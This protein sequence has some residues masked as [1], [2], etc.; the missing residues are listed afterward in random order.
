MKRS[1]LLLSLVALTTLGCDDEVDGCGLD[2]DEPQINANA[3]AGVL[4]FELARLQ[5]SNTLD[6]VVINGGCK[7]LELDLDSVRLEGADAAEFELGPVFPED[8]SA[9]ARRA[10]GIPITF[11]S[12]GRGVYLSTLV[13]ESN[14][15]NIPLYELDLIG[16]A[17]DGRIPDEA[18][19]EFF[20]DPVEVA[21]SAALLDADGN[22]IDVAIIRF[23]NLGGRSLRVS[24]YNLVDDS[25]FAFLDGT[26]E[27]SAACTYSKVCL[28]GDGAAQGCCEGGLACR[29]LEFALD[30]QTCNTSQCSAVNVTSGQ[31]SILAL[32][33]AE[34]TPTGTH[35]TTLE[36][37]SNDP[38]TPVASVT[39]TGTK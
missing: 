15:E 18:D 5:E 9:L 33:W 36:I 29:C 14:A 13:F 2:F 3:L 31:F 19:I 26:A 23:Y 20:E 12:P 21:P 30:G 22:A 35:S 28:P 32:Q 27:P 34:G 37:S 24:N 39:I 25:N 17:A 11:T 4:G 6:A 10:V 16:P 7:P 8:G 38:D 1:A